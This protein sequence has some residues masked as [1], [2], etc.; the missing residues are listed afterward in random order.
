MES[1]ISIYTLIEDGIMYNVLELEL[2]EAKAASKIPSDIFVVKNTDGKDGG[3]KRLIDLMGEKGID[4]YGM[5]QS[6]SIVLLKVNSQ[7]DQRGGTNTDLVKAIIEAIVSHPDGF[8]GEVVIA[9]NG[10][11]QYG[12]TRHG[13]SFDYE[14]NNAEDR[15]QSNHVVAESFPGHRVSTYLW[16]EITS[17][18][19]GEYSE[20]DD[21]DGYVIQSFADSITGIRVSYP[22][23]KTAHGTLA[24]FKEGVWDPETKTYDSNRL[25]L[26]NVPVLKAHFIYGVTGCVKHYMGV[27]SDKLQ[28]GGA[29]RSVR[30]GGMGIQIAR[31]RA[32][33]LNVLDAIWVNSTPGKGPRCNDD[34]ATRLNIIM[35]STDPCAMDAWA[36]QNVLMQAARL[37]GHEELSK[38]D[39]SNDDPESHGKWLRLSAEKLRE[40]GHNAV[41]DKEK[42]NVYIT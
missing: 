28:G 30:T 1:V 2:K 13:G 8:T 4:F 12:S 20:G 35:A 15:A 27:V 26:I 42:M 14:V 37:Q 40:A 6:D 18:E 10:Q 19:V 39:P 9:D 7:W 33:D 21:C 3:F 41:L 36:T 32:P 11:A 5:V 31:T 25:K 23:F 34:D 16:D 29:H 38:L 22:K 17:N 24:S